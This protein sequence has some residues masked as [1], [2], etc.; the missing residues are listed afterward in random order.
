MLAAEV[1][2]GMDPDAAY[3]LTLTIASRNHGVPFIALPPVRLC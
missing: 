3:A 2:T 1:L